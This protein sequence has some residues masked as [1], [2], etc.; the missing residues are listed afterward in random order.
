[1]EF[2]KKDL[3]NGMKVVQRNGDVMIFIDDCLY[4]RNQYERI[5]NY[6]DNLLFDRYDETDYDIVKVFE[7]E[8][9][10]GSF[11]SFELKQHKLIWERVEKTEAQ[12]KL[13]GLQKIIEDAQQK[14]EQLKEEMN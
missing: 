7:S 3:R 2:S 10:T 13:E 1:M 11:L 14:I 8:A 9:R 6:Q 4:E 5:D 12:L